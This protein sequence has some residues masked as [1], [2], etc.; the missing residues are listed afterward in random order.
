MQQNHEENEIVEI[1]IVG[2]IIYIY[3]CGKLCNDA[4]EYYA[5][6]FYVLC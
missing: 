4:V 2:N 3:T 5:K 6:Y 1:N